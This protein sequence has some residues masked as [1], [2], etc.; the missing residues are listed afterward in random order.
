MSTFGLFGLVIAF[1]GVA[2][3]S[4]CLLASAGAFGGTRRASSADTFAWAGAVA[5]ILRLSPSRSAA[6]CSS[7]AS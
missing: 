5:H 4:V 2:I 3:G 6:A 1:A 7:S